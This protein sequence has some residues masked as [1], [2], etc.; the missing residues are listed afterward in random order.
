MDLR[1]RFLAGI[2]G[3]AKEIAARMHD[4]APAGRELLREEVQRYAADVRKLGAARAFLDTE[5]SDRLAAACAA[6][7]DLADTP[8]SLRVAQAVC[9]YYVFAEDDDG[10]LNGVMGF[11]D[12]A[13]VY[14]A[15]VTALGRPDLRL[16]P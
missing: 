7:L 16:E 12:D 10:D 11:D 8:E 15:A 1:E 6:L 9:R 14:D 2:S 5:L 3:E 4:D 13:E